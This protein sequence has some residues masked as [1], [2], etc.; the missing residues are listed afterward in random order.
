M[1]TVLDNLIHRLDMAETVA[2]FTY[3]WERLSE[4]PNS[5]A[6]ARWIVGELLPKLEGQL[7]LV[8]QS[9]GR[10]LMGASFG[11]VASQ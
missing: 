8:G 11:A 1:K 9:Q 5:A 6:H 2:A 3:P 10:C 4:Y 7:S